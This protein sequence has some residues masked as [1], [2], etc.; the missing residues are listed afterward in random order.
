MISPHNKHVGL[1]DSSALAVG[2]PHHCTP[3]EDKKLL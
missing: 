2:V 3:A 1:T